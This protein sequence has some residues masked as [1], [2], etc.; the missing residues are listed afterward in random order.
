MIIKHSLNKWLPRSLQW[1]LSLWMGL[2]VGL[3]WIATTIIT[4]NNLRHEM[5]EVFDSALEETAQRILPLAALEIIGRE[6]DSISQRIATL[7]PHKEF[8]TYI[9]RNEKGTVLLRSHDA[10]E[11]VF[12]AY[13]RMGF[14][15]TATHRFYFDTAMQG[16]INIAVAEPRSYR[17]SAIDKAFYGLAV[18]FGP[19]VAL[20][21]LSVWLIIHMSMKPVRAFRNEIEQRGSGD[22]TMLSADALPLEIQPVA[23]A[24]NHLMERLKNA[25]DAERSF[26]ANAAHELRT[27]VAA[28]LAQTQRLLS[29]TTDAATTN[30]AQQIET[31]LRRLSRLSEK[32]MQ[33]AKAEGANLTTDQATDIAPMLQMIAREVAKADFNRL[34]ISMPTTPVLS[35]IDPDAFAILSRNLIE[36]ALKHGHNDEPVLINLTENG[37]LSVTNSGRAVEPETLIRLSRRFERG[38]TTASGT[39]LGLAIANAIAAGSGGKLTLASPLQGQEDGFEAKFESTPAQV[40]DSRAK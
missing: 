26:T 9:V 6:D 15:N 29:E 8:Y 23:D 34:N 36:N 32:L 31:A 19:L 3:L 38:Q 13:K 18:A 7:R 33:L 27:P 30:R 2:G 28:A 25:L 11:T 17:Q 20:S 24:V 37:V 22:F 14:V 21:L 40:L 5:D 35:K 10:D 1:R 4:I 12:P 16:T 39:G